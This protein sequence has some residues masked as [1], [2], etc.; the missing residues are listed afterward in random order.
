MVRTKMEKITKHSKLILLLILVIA[1]ILR[2]WKINEVPVSLFSDELDVGY[3][4][5]SFL[6]TGKD[7]F[8]NPLALHF[9]S[10]VENRAP[11]YIYSAVPTVAVFGITPYGIRLPAA[12]FGILGVWMMYLLVNELSL[13]KLNDNKFKHILPLVSAFILALNPWHIHYSRAAFE[14]SE[15]LFVLLTGIFFFFR[16]LK[17]PKNLWLSALFFGLAPWV[18]STAKMFI[19]MFLLFIFVVWYRNI[20]KFPK[21]ELIKAF[22]TLLILGLPLAYVIFAE[23]GAERFSYISVF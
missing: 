20:I 22:A 19:P 21:K 4:A 18:Y 3:Q 10:Y 1:A 13:Y 12:I 7:Y 8:G 11:L 9:Q 23:G 17:N 6:K 14:V 15:L 2:I 16:S 5:Y